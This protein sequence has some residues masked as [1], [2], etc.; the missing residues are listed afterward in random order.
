MPPP[1]L[2]LN[3][4]RG[5]RAG[6]VK[7]A[8]NGNGGNSRS[9]SSGSHG[10]A[11]GL[12]A[13]AAAAAAAGAAAWYDGSDDGGGETQLAAATM[14]AC[15]SKNAVKAK[16]KPPPQRWALN[17]GRGRD[18]AAA[19]SERKGKE[20]GGAVNQDTTEARAA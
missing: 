13:W 1:P 16:H 17:L 4:R 6:H 10:A 19:E 15:S 2:P 18:K 14:G 8:A 7:A 3:C 11:A 5:G 9:G 12:A 20:K